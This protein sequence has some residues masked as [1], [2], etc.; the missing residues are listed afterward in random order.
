MTDGTKEP[1]K[2]QKV[3]KF[4]RDILRATSAIGPGLGA[5]KEAATNTGSAAFEA[6]T[7]AERCAVV[8]TGIEALHHQLRTLE[9]DNNRIGE[10]IAE[11]QALIDSGK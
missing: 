7:Q 6:T 2:R 1:T 3:A 8:Q 10:L 5:I 9:A 11:R 4:D